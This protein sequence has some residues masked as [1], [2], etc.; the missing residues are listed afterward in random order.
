M[1][2]AN[3]RQVLQAHLREF[4]FQSVETWSTG[5]GVPDLNYCCDGIEGWIEC[6]RVHGFK[7]TVSPEQVGWA[8]RRLR[9]GGRVFL[10]ARRFTAKHDE[11]ILFEGWATRHL[12]DGGPITDGFLGCWENGPKRWDWLAVKSLLLHHNFGSILPGQPGQTMPAR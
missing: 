11:L 12:A 4:D 2:D 10:A 6:K 7:V 8:E 9:A 5:R 1:S 3:L